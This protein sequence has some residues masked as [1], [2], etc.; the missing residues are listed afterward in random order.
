MVSRLAELFVQVWLAPKATLVL[1]VT[2][3][4]P[5][6]TVRPPVPRV[7][8]N[9]PPAMLTLF[10]SVGAVPRM[11]RLLI[12]KSAPSVVLKFDIALEVVK[13]TSVPEPG[14]PTL[15]V[16]AASEYQL[17]AFPPVTVF[18]VLLWSPLQ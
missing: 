4:A 12:E 17:V 5:G 1:S 10:V 7:S 18:Q 13:R 11:V 14:N 9:P 16:P 2:A 15:V 6:F 8:V 3:A